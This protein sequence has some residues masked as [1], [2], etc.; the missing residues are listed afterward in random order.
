[1]AKRRDADVIVSTVGDMARLGA[2]VEQIVE[3]LSHADHS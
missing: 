3:H 1:V 2:G